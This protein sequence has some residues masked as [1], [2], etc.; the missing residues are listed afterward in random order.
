[1][2]NIL[3]DAHVAGRLTLESGPAPPAAPPAPSALC[4]RCGAA[5]LQAGCAACERE[6]EARAALE[7][8]AEADARRARAL[9]TA[10]YMLMQARVQSIAAETPL[11]SCAVSPVPLW[12]LAALRAARP[13]AVQRCSPHLLFPRLQNLCRDIRDGYSRMMNAMAAQLPYPYVALVSFMCEPSRIASC[14]HRV[15]PFHA[16]PGQPPRPAAS[17]RCASRMHLA[18]PQLPPLRLLLCLLPGRL[19]ARRPPRW[20]A[21]PRYLLVRVGLV[22]C[23]G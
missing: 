9:R 4:G 20:V 17:P 1:M 10:Q 22:S 21:S 14:G 2:S 13:A 15:F 18:P 12:P 5:P 3:A 6:A 7:A 8:A 19:A 11:N 16:L 23:C